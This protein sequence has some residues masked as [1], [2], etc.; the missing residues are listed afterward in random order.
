MS[1]NGFFKTRQDPN[2]TVR[3]SVYVRTEDWKGLQE[4]IA[5]L[6]QRAKDQQEGS[7]PLVDDAT[8]VISDLDEFVELLVGVF[9]LIVVHNDSDVRLSFKTHVLLA[10]S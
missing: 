9:W 8:M 2:P 1:L 7:W 5:H 6:E 4:H 10:C 3:R